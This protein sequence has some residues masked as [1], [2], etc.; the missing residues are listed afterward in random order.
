VTA[1][2]GTAVTCA[3]PLIEGNRILRQ[4][5][6]PQPSRLLYV[7]HLA[8]KGVDFHHP[9]CEMDLEGIVAKCA[10]APY[11]TEPSSWLKVKNPTGRRLGAGSGSRRER[12]H[13]MPGA[14]RAQCVATNR[15]WQATSLAG[16]HPRAPAVTI[17]HD[18][19]RCKLLFRTNASPN[20]S[21]SICRHIA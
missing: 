3:L 18:R 9:A 15:R 7:E 19:H 10:A 16:L 20:G 4:V 8:C 5:V 21:K 6:P 2:G 17:P 13:S 12:V 1:L 14:A 11:G